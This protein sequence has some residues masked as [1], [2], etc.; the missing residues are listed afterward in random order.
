[1]QGFSVP[2]RDVQLASTGIL[3]DVRYLSLGPLRQQQAV[4]IHSLLLCRHLDIKF[5]KNN[6]KC[7][8]F[9]GK[10]I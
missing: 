5:S 6:R 8:K 9:Q 2:A 1:V 10:T 4:L 7:G 3:T